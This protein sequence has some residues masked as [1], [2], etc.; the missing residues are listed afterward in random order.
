MTEES[1]EESTEDNRQFEAVLSR[2]DALMK[3]SHPSPLPQDAEEFAADVPV[4]TEIYQGAVLQAV[5]VAEQ[6]APP[7][8]TDY[9]MAPPAPEMALP[10]VVEDVVA[11]ASAAEAMPAPASV[12]P[13]VSLEPLA[14]TR[15]Q[16]VETIMAELLPMLQEMVA[17]VVQEELYYAQQNLTLRIGQEAERL[18]RQRLLREV[19]PK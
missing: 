4:L 11:E 16:D 1:T 8:L 17:K 15:E 10:E 6:E 9:V 2:L 12:E 14:S 13:P 5:G 19:K 7:V 3:R 18:L